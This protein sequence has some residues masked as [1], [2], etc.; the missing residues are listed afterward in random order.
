MPVSKYRAAAA[1]D[2]VTGNFWAL[3]LPVVVLAVVWGYA[4]VIAAA[5]ENAS[6]KRGNR[7]ELIGILEPILHIGHNVTVVTQPWLSS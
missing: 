4:A 5:R 1:D 7:T 3:P 2:V 6:I